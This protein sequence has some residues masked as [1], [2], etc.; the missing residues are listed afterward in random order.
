MK[1]NNHFIIL[2][3]LNDAFNVIS[4]VNQIQKYLTQN[5]IDSRS[6]F[7]LKRGRTF[8]ATAST[9]PA[10]ENKHIHVVI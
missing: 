9:L 5:N 3:K 1:Q 7:I 6:I 4:M 10:V 2:L 8:T